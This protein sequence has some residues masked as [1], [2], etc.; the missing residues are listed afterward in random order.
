MNR[1]LELLDIKKIDYKDTGGDILI[2]CLNPDHNDSHP[3]LRVDRETGVMHCLSCGFG[4]GVP[5]IY[6]YFN[7]S[8]Y[9][10]SPRLVMVQRTIR[11]IL[12]SNT[13]LSIPESAMF[14]EE[15]YRGIKASTFKKYFAFQD[16]QQWPDRVVFP[17]ADSVGKIVVFIGR[18]YQGSAP[19]KYLL[20]PKDVAAPIYPMRYNCPVLLMVEGMFDMLNLEDK[21]INNVAACFGTHQFSPDNISDK[22]SSF[23]LAG[24]KIIVILLDKDKAGNIAAEKISRYIREKT[25]LIPIVANHL[26][27]DDKDPGELDEDEVQELNNQIEIL[28]AE[29][30]KNDV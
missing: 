20:K 18:S 7:E 23:I 29:T 24:T 6:H 22:L 3:S 27:P 26:L 16:L 2:R 13:S 9:R 14:F 5:S 11:D 4:K 12:R 25:R 21:G 30:L 1:I 8:M 19:P 17:I 10:Q 15:D 28:V